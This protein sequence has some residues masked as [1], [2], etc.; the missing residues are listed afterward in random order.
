[1]ASKLT[2]VWYVKLLAGAAWLMRSRTL[3]APA[4]DETNR[5]IG[6]RVMRPSSCNFERYNITTESS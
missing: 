6:T 3:A 5:V 2:E 1:M 4:S